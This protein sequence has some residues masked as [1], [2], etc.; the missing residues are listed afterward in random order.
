MKRQATGWEEIVAT[1]VMTEDSYPEYVKN[2]HK[3]SK[4]KT[5]N[6]LEK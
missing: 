6:A 2:P 4:K 1:H 3:V 5:D